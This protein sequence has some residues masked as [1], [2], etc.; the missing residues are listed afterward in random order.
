[1]PSGYRI[2]VTRK[3]KRYSSR[4][5]VY[6]IIVSPV[7]RAEIVQCLGGICEIIPTDQSYQASPS[8]SNSIFF[9]WKY[10]QRIEG[11]TAGNTGPRNGRVVKLLQ[12]SGIRSRCGIANYRRRLDKIDFRQRQTDRVLIAAIIARHRVIRRNR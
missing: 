12:S 9:S 11:R 6:D 7:L 4:R 5:I 10:R 8:K 2:R 1:V 3:R